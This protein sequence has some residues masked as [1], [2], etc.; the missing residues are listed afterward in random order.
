MVVLV[1]AFAILPVNAMDGEY[2]DTQER[3][4]ENLELEDESELNAEKEIA[5]SATPISGGLSDHVGDDTKKSAS[6]LHLLVWIIHIVLILLIV[7]LLLFRRRK[8]AKE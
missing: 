6:L 5:D 3:E 7:W 2:L 4:N 1:C 8:R